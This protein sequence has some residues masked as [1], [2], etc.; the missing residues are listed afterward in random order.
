MSP[1]SHPNKSLFDKHFRL[2]APSG[3][4]KTGCG[5]FFARSDTLKR[6]LD[7]KNCEDRC[8]STRRTP[9]LVSEYA[10]LYPDRKDDFERRLARYMNRKPSKT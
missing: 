7:A 8:F 2:T 6:H 4:Y 3:E 5:K 1:L 10:A 9:I